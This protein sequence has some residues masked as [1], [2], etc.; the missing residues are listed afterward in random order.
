MVERARAASKSARIFAIAL[1]DNGAGAQAAGSVTFSGPATA[2]GTLN[3]YIGGR[4]FTVGV[5]SGM[6]AAQLAT[7]FVAAITATALPLHAQ[8]FGEDVAFIRKHTP[9][10]VLADAKTGARIAVCPDLQGRVM[11]SSA[12]GDP[13]PSFGWVNRELLGSGGNGAGVGV[14][15]S[16][17]FGCGT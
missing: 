16:G 7:A 5:N 4:R 14:S 17:M 6:T 15:S 11:T 3:A 9:V 13:G 8:T 1:S 2:A 12:G 10:V